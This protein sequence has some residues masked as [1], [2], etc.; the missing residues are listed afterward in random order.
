MAV[1]WR[2][3]LLVLGVIGFVVAAV[4]GWSEFTGATAWMFLL[5]WL[6]AALGLASRLP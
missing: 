2:V 5:A 3:I 1:T 4:L 6:A